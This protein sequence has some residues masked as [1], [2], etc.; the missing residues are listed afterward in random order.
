MDRVG[1]VTNPRA[2]RTDLANRRVSTPGPVAWR[3]HAGGDSTGGCA[4]RGRGLREEIRRVRDPHLICG[5]GYEDAGAHPGEAAMTETRVRIALGALFLFAG[6]M[7][8]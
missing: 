4:G 1:N 6:V 5:R 8:V 7:P 3:L 2:Q